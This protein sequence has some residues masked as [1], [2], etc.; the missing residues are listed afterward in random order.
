MNANTPR[1]V[2]LG[3]AAGRFDLDL[4]TLQ[5]W[6]ERHCVSPALIVNGMELFSAD[7][8]ER[9]ISQLLWP[10][11]AGAPLVHTD[12]EGV[13]EFAE[14]DPLDDDDGPEDDEGP[15]DDPIMRG[16]LDISELLRGANHG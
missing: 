9:A 7:V 3:F 4:L 6:L 11:L 12:P 16:G 5:G 8:V 10:D 14:D 13:V 1:I 15:D 2:S